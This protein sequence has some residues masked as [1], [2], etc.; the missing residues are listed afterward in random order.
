[1]NSYKKP[2]KL[3]RKQRKV[4][5]LSVLGQ[6][7]LQGLHVSPEGETHILSKGLLQTDSLLLALEAHS[8]KLNPD[9]QG[10]V[11]ATDLPLPATQ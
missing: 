3:S 10:G 9:G 11:T 7:G 6:N 8:P 1:M 5:N 4:G 2:T